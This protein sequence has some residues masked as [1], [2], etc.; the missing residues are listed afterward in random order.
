[1]SQQETT[2]AERHLEKTRLLNKLAKEICPCCARGDTLYAPTNKPGSPGTVHY[3]YHHSDART[4]FA[5]DLYKWAKEVGILF[6]YQTEV[7]QK[8]S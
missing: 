1:M 7:P 3:D 4:C 6:T 5:S 2:A 8:Q